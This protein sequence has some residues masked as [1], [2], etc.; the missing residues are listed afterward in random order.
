MHS[1]NIKKQYIWGII[2]AATLFQTD[3]YVATDSYQP[4]SVTWLLYTPK[5]VSHTLEQTQIYS[6]LPSTVD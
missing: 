4:G 1:K 2:A 3:V 5:P 6:R